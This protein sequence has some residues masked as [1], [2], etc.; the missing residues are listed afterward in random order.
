MEPGAED[1]QESGGIDKTNTTTLRFLREVDEQTGVPTV[2]ERQKK[3][4]SVWAG[5][6][7]RNTTLQKTDTRCGLLFTENI[8][9]SGIPA[10]DVG[11]CS[12]RGCVLA[13]GGA[14]N[15]AEYIQRSKP[16]N[17]PVQ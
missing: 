4:S 13:S 16:A 8:P 2:L 15:T 11:D 14:G 5:I 3:V 9:D 7:N 17:H 10:A 1:T 12:R 6:K